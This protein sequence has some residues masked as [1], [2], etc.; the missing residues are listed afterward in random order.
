MLLNTLFDKIIPDLLPIID[1]YRKSLS[2][3]AIGHLLRKYEGYRLITG[4]DLKHDSFVK[5]F[6]DF[7]KYNRGIRS[8]D[9]LRGCNICGDD[10]DL[11]FYSYY[12][13]C[14][15][16]EIIYP[17]RIRTGELVKFDHDDI[18]DQLKSYP[19]RPMEHDIGLFVLIN[20]E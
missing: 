15:D 18:M 12:V 14:L 10:I 7:Y 3:F 19:Y 5:L 8:L 4:N 13:R 1:Q 6:S 11:M 17:I 16:S 2:S 9:I 20:Y